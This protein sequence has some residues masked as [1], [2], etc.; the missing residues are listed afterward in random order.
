MANIQCNS[1]FYT[2]FIFKKIICLIIVN[3]DLPEQILVTL[4]CIKKRLQF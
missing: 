2:S 3:L 4:K 1:G